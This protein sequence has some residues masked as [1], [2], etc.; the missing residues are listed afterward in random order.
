[1][2]ICEAALENQLFEI[3]S[4]EIIFPDG[5]YVKIPG[6]GRVTGRPFEN[7]WD[8][9]G[10]PLAVYLSLKKWYKDRPNVSATTEA[11]YLKGILPVK[12]SARYLVDEV[13]EP[14]EDILC[15]QSEAQMRFLF[16]NLELLFDPELE[17]SGDTE[18]V[19]VA[20][21]VRTEEDIRIS[22]EYVPPLF[23]ANASARFW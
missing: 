5:T 15:H 4:L 10:K 11:A 2:E 6:N 16:Y 12:G 3:D 9:E 23:R 1:M 14:I 22:R 17:E 13:P 20:E 19:K 7:L 21:L 8:K 18:V